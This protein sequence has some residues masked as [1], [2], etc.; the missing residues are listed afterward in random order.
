MP[1]HTAHI[2]AARRVGH[3]NI[4]ALRR[5]GRATARVD[6]GAQLLGDGVGRLR[7]AGLE[8]GLGVAVDGVGLGGAAAEGGAADGASDFE[9]AGGMGEVG[10]DGG[11]HLRGRGLVDGWKGRIVLC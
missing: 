5:L 1:E 10:A 9:H 11:L 2:L 8:E 7:A 6:L 3:A 4:F